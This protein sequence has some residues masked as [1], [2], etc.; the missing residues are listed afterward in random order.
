MPTLLIA[1]CRGVFVDPKFESELG[2]R[3]S[4]GS[5]GRNLA[6]EVIAAALAARKTR[7]ETGRVCVCGIRTECPAIF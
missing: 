3:A 6:R 5:D 1:L 4:K 2:G 7:D